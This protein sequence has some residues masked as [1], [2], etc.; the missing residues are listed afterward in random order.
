MTLKRALI[1][2]AVVIFVP[3]IALAIALG[4]SFSG[5]SKV[6]DGEALG[7]IGRVVQDGHTTVDFL[8]IG[9]GK[10]ALIDAGNDKSGA[11]LLA[12]LQRRGLTPDA[13]TAIFLTHGHP[14]HVAAVSLFPKADVYALTA[15]VP[16]AEGREKPRGPL[17]RLFPLQPRDFKVT[18]P[19][20]DGDRIPVGTE[21]VEVFAV[22]G[23]TVGSAAYLVRGL[24]FLGDSADATPDG[25]LDPCIWIASDD[26]EQN[27]AS[28][29]ALEK[30]LEPRASEVTTLVFAHSGTLAGF[31]P[32]KAYAGG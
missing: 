9:G 16:M 27:H 28:L 24:L 2:L 5:L 19:V 3:L 7:S 13:V 31:Q 15:E 32:L 11:P 25:K 14:D 30:R 21:T 8:D 12:E 29:R 20:N 26:A 10:I 17:T 1:A 6:K 22:P 18:K 23:H 4:V